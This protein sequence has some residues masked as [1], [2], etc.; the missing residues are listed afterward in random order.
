MVPS[1]TTPSNLHS[2][3]PREP[4]FSIKRSPSTQSRNSR[5]HS[6][7]GPT[8][9]ALKA[10]H[11]LAP[12]LNRGPKLIRKLYKATHLF[13]VAAVVA[14]IGLQASRRFDMTASQVS[15]LQTAELYFTLAFDFEV[16]VRVFASLPEWRTLWEPENAADVVLAVL[17]SVIQ[18]PIIRDSDA[19]P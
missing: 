8:V 3:P 16:I 19:Y 4:F 14:D 17:T 10:P 7:V 11:S 1:W 13:W 12:R 9:D 18:M 2:P 5:N 15:T 6:I